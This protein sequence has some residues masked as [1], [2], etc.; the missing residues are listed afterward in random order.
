MSQE[1][2]WEELLKECYSEKSEKKNGDTEIT[3]FKRDFNFKRMNTTKK[4]NKY[5]HTEL[6]ELD[7]KKILKNVTER[8]KADDLAQR[9]KEAF[10]GKES[11]KIINASYTVGAT[12]ANWKSWDNEK[13]K[14]ENL[15]RTLSGQNVKMAIETLKNFDADEIDSKM[16]VIQ[17]LN[18]SPKTLEKYTKLFENKENLDFITDEKEAKELKNFLVNIKF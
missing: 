6:L 11:H 12:T 17:D 4:D 3:G 9:R 8:E 7:S 15:K 18:N 10:R 2:T 13:I 14:K 16:W 1:I 5:Y